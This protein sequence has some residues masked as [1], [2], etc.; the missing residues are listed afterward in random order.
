LTFEFWTS[1][2]TA[3]YTVEFTIYVPQL[4]WHAVCLTGS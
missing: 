2:I 4:R 1:E 3:P